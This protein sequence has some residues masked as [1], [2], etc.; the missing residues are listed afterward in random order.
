MNRSRTVPAPPD[1]S[2]GWR[3]D[4]AMTAGTCGVLIPA[5]LAV[6]GAFRLCISLGWYVA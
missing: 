4:L 5:Y 3:A 2:P 1:N 6:L